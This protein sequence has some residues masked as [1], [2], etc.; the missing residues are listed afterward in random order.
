MIR[1]RDRA[2]AGAQLAQKLRAYAGR[3]AVVLALPRGG[4]PV[5]AAVAAALGAPLD[6]VLAR[7]IG[8]PRQPE[9][10]L[11]AVVDGAEPTI[12]RND[13]IL[14]A[15]DVSAAEFASICKRELAEI[16]RR[17]RRYLGARLPVDIAGRV[18]IIVDDGIATGA[19]IRAALRATRRRQ[20]AH[21]VLAVPVAA[22]GALESLRPEADAVVCLATP[23]RFHGVGEFY[24]DFRQLRDEE[25]TAALAPT[26]VAA[27]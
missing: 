1:F 11:G 6:I 20:P 13:E 25:V 16:E 7:K 2:A 22:A 27:A 21:L 26:P 19:T 10:A 23:E 12:V 14:A 15:T 18:A 8:A 5:A 3:N 4:V 9:L 17:R 24:D